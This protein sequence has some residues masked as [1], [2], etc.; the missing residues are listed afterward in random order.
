MFKKKVVLFCLSAF[1][2]SLFLGCSGNLGTNGNGDGNGDD[3]APTH[4]LAKVEIT[5]YLVEG[6]GVDTLFVPKL[7]STETYYYEIEAQAYNEEDGEISPWS[8]NFEWQ[9]DENGSVSFVKP[10]APMGELNAVVVVDSHR[11]NC[12]EVVALRDWFDTGEEYE[13]SITV[14]VTATQGTISVVSDSLVVVG[15]VNLEGEWER[16]SDH[17]ICNVRQWS[18]SAGPFLP[19]GGLVITKGDS[20]YYPNIEGTWASGHILENGRRVEYTGYSEYGHADYAYIKNL[21]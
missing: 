12:A 10:V 16:E 7:D 18:H 6:N 20:L 9:T 1:V 13:P 21:D 3:P 15:V 11:D 5:G 17:Q 2:M 14:T 8:I 19:L 4:Y